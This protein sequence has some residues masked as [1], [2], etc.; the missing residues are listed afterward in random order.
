MMSAIWSSLKAKR[1]ENAVGF[2]IIITCKFF[3]QPVD[4]QRQS[5]LWQAHQV[6]LSFNL[7]HQRAFARDHALCAGSAIK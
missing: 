7:M 6:A 4:P 2:V 3:A 1:L 5:F